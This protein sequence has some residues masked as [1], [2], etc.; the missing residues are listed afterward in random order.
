MADTIPNSGGVASWFAG[1][2]S[3]A[4]FGKEIATFGA[5]L[6]VFADNVNGI[7]PEAVAAA[8]N[9]GKAL[10]EMADTIPNSGGVAS[11]FAGENSLAKFGPDIADFGTHMKTFSDNVVGIN[12][13]AVTAAANAGKVL[14]EMASIIPNEGGVASWFAGENSLSKFGPNIADFG[15]H[16]KTF[17]DNVTGINIEAVTAA[18]NA[19]KALAEMAS[20]IPNEGGV[21]SWFAG[22]NSLAKFGP[23]IAAFG[24]HMKTF[25]DNVTGINVEAVTAAAN[26]GKT[27][28][29]MASIIP[30]EGGVRSWFSGENSLAKFGPNIAAFGAHMKTFSDN[31]AGLNV[32]E[33]TAAANAGKALAEMTKTMPKEGGVKSWFS[34]ENGLAKFGPQ[35]AEFGTHMKTFSDNVVGI[36]VQNVSGAADAGKVLAEM[37]KI[38]PKKVKLET[39]GEQLEK[40]GKSMCTF[41]ATVH[42]IDADTLV[43]LVTSFKTM[44][45]DIAKIGETG[46]K[47]FVNAFKDAKP[48]AKSAGENLAKAVVASIKTNANRV[49]FKSA[50]KYLVE[51]FADGIKEN[52]FKAKA[53]AAAMAE[54]A[55]K[56]AKKEL[57]V[58]SPSKV[59]RKLGTSIPEGLAQGI[60]KLGGMVKKSS[61]N[62][63]DTAINST[64]NTLARVYDVVNGDVNV[65]PTISPVIDLSNVRSGANAISNMLGL[66]PS[67]G[68]LANVGAINSTMA[69]YSNNGNGEVVSEIR[70]LRK[71]LDN[72][73]NTTYNVNGVTYDDGSNI[74]DAVRTITRAVVR[75]RRT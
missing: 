55:Y 54:A 61:V 66:Q 47:G 43:S 74:T 46:A 32:E 26:S 2:N 30:N 7:N 29:E 22:E 64:A 19:G 38:V 13:E 36:N 3:V 68:V 41:A 8:A 17:S 5:D 1:E 72:V 37:T 67:I 65:Q 14:A 59:F 56:A 75:E 73:G 58:N 39:F 31:V 57:D 53:K 51:G 69:G 35:L 6:K 28:A 70:K 60:E 49:D 25:S 9:A 4:K 18:A 45:T 50:G 62:M 16:M 27:L 52:T 12:I 33:V 23:N 15:T 34:G 24:A 48:T 11:W 40:F 20:I 42:A 63:A 71:G 44:M 21:A 10:A